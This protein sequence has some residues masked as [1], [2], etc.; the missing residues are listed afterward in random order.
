MPRVQEITAPRDDAPT[1]LQLCTFEQTEPSDVRYRYG[2]PQS[3]A[4]LRGGERIARMPRI[5]RAEDADAV[6]HPFTG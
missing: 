1:Q 4:F 5:L 3:K 2:K 6:R